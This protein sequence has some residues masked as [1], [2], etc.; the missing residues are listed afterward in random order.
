MMFEVKVDVKYPGCHCLP[1]PC[2]E[3]LPFRSMALSDKTALQDALVPMRHRLSNRYQLTVILTN[4]HSLH[5]LLLTGVSYQVKSDANPAT[6]LSGTFLAITF[7]HF[8]L[9]V[10]DVRC[11]S[12]VRCAH[13]Q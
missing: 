10:I 8:L 7:P 4:T 11:G 12:W 2:R 6:Y 1:R 13:G 3:Q 5:E 9:T